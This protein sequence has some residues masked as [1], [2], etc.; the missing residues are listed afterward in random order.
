MYPDKFYLIERIRGQL[1]ARVIY[2]ID[3]NEIILHDLASV[4]FPLWLA[5][6]H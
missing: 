4:L 5:M 6:A 3:Q 1:V 2:S